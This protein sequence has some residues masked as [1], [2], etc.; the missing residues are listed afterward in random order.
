MQNPIHWQLTLHTADDIEAISTYYE[1]PQDLKQS[2]EFLTLLAQYKGHKLT[3]S[4]Y[5]Q[6][7]SGD[8]VFSDWLCDY[9]I[10]TE[11]Q[12]DS[13]YNKKRKELK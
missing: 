3:L 10:A 13:V 2:E 11:K 9:D 8:I 12:L 4:A 7:R 6:K 1:T 5:L